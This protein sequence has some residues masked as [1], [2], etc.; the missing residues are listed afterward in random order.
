MPPE[1]FPAVRVALDLAHENNYGGGA[2][3]REA[4]CR[5]ILDQILTGYEGIN[6]EDLAY[7]QNRLS[8]LVESRN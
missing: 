1:L 3:G 5:C 2:S 4:Y 8:Q 7:L 6:A